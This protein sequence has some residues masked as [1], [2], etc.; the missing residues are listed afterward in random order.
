MFYLKTF[1]FFDSNEFV[2]DS[3]N[4]EQK[5]ALLFDE[6]RGELTTGCH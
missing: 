4:P 3:D 2:S 6:N 1:T 5:K